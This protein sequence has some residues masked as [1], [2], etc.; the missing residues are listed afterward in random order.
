VLVLEEPPG[1]HFF[2]LIVDDFDEVR[3]FGLLPR[4][5]FAHA[6]ANVSIGDYVRVSNFRVPD[7]VELF[8]KPV[9]YRDLRRTNYA[10]RIIK[11]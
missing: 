5:L 2:G 4:G 3:Q 11:S 10:R 8:Y 7:D 1:Q 9:V 6:R